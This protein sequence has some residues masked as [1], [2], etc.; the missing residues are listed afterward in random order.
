MWLPAFKAMVDRFLDIGTDRQAPAWLPVICA[1]YSVFMFTLICL[2][3]MMEND[4]GGFGGNEWC[5]FDSV[6]FYIP[7]DELDH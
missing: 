3:K 6:F 2:I 5:Q 4:G 7:K 1:L